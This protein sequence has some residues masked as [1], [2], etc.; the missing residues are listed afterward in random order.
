VFQFTSESKFYFYF[1][2]CGKRFEYVGGT[3][4]AGAG[5]GAGAARSLS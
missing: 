5:V 1:G 3:S 2:N 4:G